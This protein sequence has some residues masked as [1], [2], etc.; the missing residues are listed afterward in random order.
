MDCLQDSTRVL[1]VYVRDQSICSRD[2]G[3][4]SQPLLPTTQVILQGFQSFSTTNLLNYVHSFKSNCLDERWKMEGKAGSKYAKYLFNLE[5][6]KAD[7]PRE[8][9]EQRPPS[10]SQQQTRFAVPP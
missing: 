6:Q 4:I 9:R 7:Q 10:C 5:G 8:P 2:K 3:K 1:V